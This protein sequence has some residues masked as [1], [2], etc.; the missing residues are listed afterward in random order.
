ME[1]YRGIYESDDRTSSE[2]QYE[3]DEE[4]SKQVN[5]LQKKNT[6]VVNQQDKL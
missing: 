3:T 1:E 6:Q 5:F 2:E 4:Q